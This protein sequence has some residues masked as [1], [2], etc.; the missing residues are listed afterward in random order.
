MS[1]ETPSKAD[2]AQAEQMLK[3]GAPR[4]RSKNPMRVS[5]KGEGIHEY[6]DE[7]LWKKTTYVPSSK[8]YDAGEGRGD[9]KKYKDAGAYKKGGSVARGGGAATRGTKFKGVC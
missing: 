4:Y 6:A 1:K 5:D 2:K 9:P 7:P 3:K 8:T